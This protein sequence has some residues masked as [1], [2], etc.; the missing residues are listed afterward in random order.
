MTKT[1]S[2]TPIFDELVAEFFP[3]RAKGEEPEPAAEA[4]AEPA[5]STPDGE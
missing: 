4:T 1:E 3:K 5:E 2:G